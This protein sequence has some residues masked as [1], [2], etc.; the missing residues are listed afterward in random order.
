MTNIS[1]LVMIKQ[2]LKEL[3]AVH[4]RQLMY[5]FEQEITQFVEL[6]DGKFLGVNVDG[7]PFL[8][9]LE[10]AGSWAYGRIRASA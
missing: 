10:Q 6:E 1:I 9:I 2:L 5:A 3:D 7:I 4:K 8:E